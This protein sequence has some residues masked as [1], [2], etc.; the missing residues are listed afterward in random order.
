MTTGESEEEYQPDGS[1]DEEYNWYVP[2]F[3]HEKGPR[4]HAM[5]SLCSSDTMHDHLIS[6]HYYRVW[7][8]NQGVSAEG[9]MKL[10]IHIKILDITMKE[11]HVDGTDHIMVFQF[12]IHCVTEADKM[13]MSDGQGYLALPTYLTEGAK[14]QFTSM[15][16]DIRDGGITCWP[17]AINFSSEVTKHPI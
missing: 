14:S 15:K 9:M 3:E 4:H 5:S 1:E 11:H 10:R 2:F 16:T 8:L 13:N 17:E 12:L 7:N 6:Y